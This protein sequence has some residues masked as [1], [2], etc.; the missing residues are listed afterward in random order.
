MPRGNVP[1][2]GRFNREFKRGS[3]PWHIRPGEVSGGALIVI[4]TPEMSV[5]GSNS[6]TGAFPTNSDYTHVRGTPVELPGLPDMKSRTFFVV[7]T[8]TSM[9]ST[10]N[11]ERENY[12]SCEGQVGVSFYKEGNIIYRNV[13]PPNPYN[14]YFW[15]L[16][17]IYASAAGSGGSPAESWAGESFGAG[18]NTSIIPG[19]PWETEPGPVKPDAVGLYLKALRGTY[20]CSAKLTFYWEE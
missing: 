18:G 20:D 11:D 2:S 3:W 6:F 16:G 15:G 19:Q 14:V 17:S 9:S 13:S 5:S 1:S 7:T 8:I 12:L 10:T 4:Q